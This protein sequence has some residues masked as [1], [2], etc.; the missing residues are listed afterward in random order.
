MGQL[1]LFMHGDDIVAAVERGDW[2]AGD[3]RGRPLEAIGE[4][5]ARKLAEA[6][7]GAWAGGLETDILANGVTMPISVIVRD[8]K[9]PR[10]DNGHHRV[11]VA[12]EHDMYVPIWWSR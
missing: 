1:A 2:I 3:W 6:R 12:A 7:A 9:S 10:I 4:L 8:D 11:A 5:W